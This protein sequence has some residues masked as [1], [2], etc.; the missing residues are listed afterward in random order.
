MS[1]L[2]V[3]LMNALSAVLLLAFAAMALG[4]VLHH[5]ARQPA[6]ILQKIQF[7]I[8]IK[9]V[10]NFCYFCLLKIIITV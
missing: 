7:R 9:T 10:Y 4:L 3:R 8:I 2:D 5:L 1:P 6:F